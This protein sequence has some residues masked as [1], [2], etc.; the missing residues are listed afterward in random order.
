MQD[1]DDHGDERDA[2]RPRAPSSG[3]KTIMSTP[4][5]TATKP[6]R[7][8]VVVALES[9]SRIASTPRARVVRSPDV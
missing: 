8:I 2:L 7:T 1:D 4:F 9:V 3:S 5:A 6:A